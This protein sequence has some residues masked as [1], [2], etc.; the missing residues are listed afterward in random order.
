VR[1]DDL[2]DLVTKDLLESLGERLIFL[3]LLFTLLLLVLG[4]LKLDGGS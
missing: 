2:L 3:F 1:N 4:F